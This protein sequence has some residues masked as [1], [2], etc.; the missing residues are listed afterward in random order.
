M[1]IVWIEV[2]IPQT[3]RQAKNRHQSKG[4]R[5]DIWKKKSKCQYKH[6]CSLT[7]CIVYDI[8]HTTGKQEKMHATKNRSFTLFCTQTST[9]PW[10]HTVWRHKHPPEEERTS[11][12]PQDVVWCNI[13]KLPWDTPHKLQNGISPLKTYMWCETY[14]CASGLTSLKELLNYFNLIK[15]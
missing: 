13:S 7:K 5:Y 10:S 11:C 8:I 6:Q 15:K 3:L 12:L 14:H 9:S 1:N 2:V 4:W